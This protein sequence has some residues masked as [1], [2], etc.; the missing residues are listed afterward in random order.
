[1]DAA[2][3][4]QMVK[5]KSWGLHDGSTILSLYAPL[6][7]IHTAIMLLA[8]SATQSLHCAMFGWADH[9]LNDLFREAWANEHI[10]VKLALDS[11]QAAG[12]GERALL[13]QWPANV[14]TSSLV[15]GQSSKH[16]ISHMKLIVADDCYVTGS[17]NVS[18]G[19]EVKQ[20]NHALFI[21]SAKQAQEA[22]TRV[23]Q[24]F[25]EMASQPGCQSHADLVGV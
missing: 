12:V 7:D 24:V 10:L 1:M 15:I 4:Q 3:W 6:D 25:A 14:Y 5:C 16:A 2:T 17:T 19:G 18:A 8:K 9:E 11:T 21:W 22:Q 23:S 20:N 13:K